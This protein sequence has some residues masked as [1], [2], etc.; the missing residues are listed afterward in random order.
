MYSSDQFA[1]EWGPVLSSCHRSTASDQLHAALQTFVTIPPARRLASSDNDGLLRPFT[2]TEVVC[3][4]K[5]LR[6]HKSAGHD[7]RNNDFCTDISSPMVLV[8]IVIS[9]QILVGADLP[10]SFPTAL[11]IPVRKKGDSDDSMDYRPIS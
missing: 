10:P 2:D 11:I 9:I 8:L 1:S 5:T 6:R 4:I 7:G 3:A